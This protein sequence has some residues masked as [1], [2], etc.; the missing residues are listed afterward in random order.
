MVTDSSKK[1]LKIIKTRFPILEKIHYIV[2]S[3]DVKERKPASDGYLKVLKKYN[4]VDY[5]DIIGF[6]D[7][8]KG[9][10]SMSN[11]IY[12]TVCVNNQ[13]YS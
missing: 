7:S 9:I 2:T 11:V 3:D 1:T 4:N 8:Y 13:N 5:Y 12:N 6:E 10:I